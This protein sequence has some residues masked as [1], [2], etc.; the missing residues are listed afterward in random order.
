MRN[1]SGFGN[2]FFGVDSVR[3]FV[4]YLTNRFGLT[5][6]IRLR[7]NQRFE[8][9]TQREFLA[10]EVANLKNGEQKR[11]AGPNGTA[12]PIDDAA[13]SSMCLRITCIADI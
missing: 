7:R 8:L 3:L 4:R 13:S 2:L 12:T 1:V 9:E 6:L 10:A 5:Y 11:N